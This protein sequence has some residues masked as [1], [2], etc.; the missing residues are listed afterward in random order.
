MA[1]KKKNPKKE[2]LLKML[3]EMA[4]SDDI[5]PEDK[6]KLKE[7]SLEID[8]IKIYSKFTYILGYAIVYLFKIILMY[9]ISL[10]VLGL[11][12]NFM[13]IDKIYVFLI[14]L[15]V[16]LVCNAVS[17]A[18]NVILDIKKTFNVVILSYLFIVMVFLIINIYFK[19][20]EFGTIWLFYLLLVNIIDEYIIYKIIRRKLWTEK[21]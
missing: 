4:D 18:T 9:I 8:S 15:G 17:L 2:D 3:N 5:T 21:Y 1:K 11:F 19:V 7:L 14:P 10:V 13:V 12:V 20:F 16:S 6:E